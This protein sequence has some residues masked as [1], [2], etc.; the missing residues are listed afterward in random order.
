MKFRD[1]SKT[2]ALSY[3]KYTNLA[4]AIEPLEGRGLLVND[5]NQSAHGLTISKTLLCLELFACP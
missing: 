4:P 1:S 2:L 3:E 5:E